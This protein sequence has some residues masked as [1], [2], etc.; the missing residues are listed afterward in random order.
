MDLPLR[1]AGSARLRNPT[2]HARDPNPAVSSR[3]R[4]ASLAKD[5]TTKMSLGPAE[6]KSGPRSRRLMSAEIP[7]SL[8]IP[9][10]KRAEV[11]FGAAATL[12]QSCWAQLLRGVSVPWITATDGPPQNW[13]ADFRRGRTGGSNRRTGT[14]RR[15]SGIRI[16][17]SCATMEFP[18]RMFRPGVSMVKEDQCTESVALG[19][20][21]A[22]YVLRS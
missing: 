15:M 4:F 8:S 6:R 18:P 2:P 5:G 20:E 7:S 11:S 9:S 12:T 13:R 14:L 17:L 1:R 22:N 3:I 21:A 19:K 16:R 10:M